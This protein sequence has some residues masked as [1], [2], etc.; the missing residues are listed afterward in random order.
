MAGRHRGLPY[1]VRLVV[2]GL[3]CV[4]VALAAGAGVVAAQPSSG[5]TADEDVLG[6]LQAQ[7]RASHVPSAAYAIVADGGVTGSGALGAGVTVDTPFLLGSLSKS[8]TALA[9]M[10]LVDQG[11]IALDSPITQYIS[12]FRTAGG[13]EPITVRH[14]LEQTSGL[15]TAAGTVDLYEPSVTLEDRV[16]ALADIELVSTPGA[17]F[18]YCN[19]NYATLGLL[20]ETVSGQAFADYVQ[21]HIFDPLRMTR[22][23]TDLDAAREAGL[24]E[25]TTTVFGASV[26]R[27]TPAFPGAL[28]DGYLISTAGDLGHYLEF[29]MTGSFDGVRLLSEAGLA[30]MHAPAVPI[31]DDG[32]LSGVDDYG[33]GW[34]AGSVAGQP[35]VRHD[36][37]LANYH[38]NLGF[39]PDRG[40]GLVVLTA[41][42]PV[43]VDSGTAFDG[44]MAMLAGDGAP[45]ISNAFTV[46]YVV[47]GAVAAVALLA[48]VLATRGQVRRARTLPRRLRDNGFVAG[49]LLP[50]LRDL[51][52]AVA[53]Y[54][55][56]FV[57][58]GYLG[59]GGPV[60]IAVAFGALPDVTVLVLVIVA[61]LALRALAWV[62]YGMLVRARAGVPRPLPT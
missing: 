58:V 2:A 8:F 49:A 35:V 55:A 21:A 17:E 57:G 13:S 19:K 27:D 38:S 41:A 31:A 28:P 43:L 40:V 32:A 3:V 42:N 23:F 15:P 4:T 10:Q 1:L 53:V 51:A 37:D 26:E 11:R 16:R 50:G 62:G 18:H 30:L 25:G 45:S 20:V 54:V 24:V 6:Y 48:M 56:V 52:A 59:F 60:S 46:T 47:V 22:S 61:F 29:Q 44:A 39:L 34:G 7:L 9:V 12:W 14:L 33:F 5:S 36:G